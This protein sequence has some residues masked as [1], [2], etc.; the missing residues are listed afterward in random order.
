MGTIAALVLTVILFAY[1]FWPQ[2]R[3]FQQAAK[4]RL[5]YLAE[6]KTTVYDNLRDLNFEYQAGKYPDEDYQTQRTSLEDEAAG[7]L[8]EM[9]VLE[10][11]AG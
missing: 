2:G 6:R 1:V 3:L 10:G 4:T 11:R 8:H 9:D 7:I 5:D